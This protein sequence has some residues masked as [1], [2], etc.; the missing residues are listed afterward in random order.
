MDSVTKEK[1]SDL[2]IKRWKK[3]STII[4]PNL[5][6]DAKFETK[7]Q[8]VVLK[9]IKLQNKSLEEEVEKVLNIH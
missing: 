3:K 2:V 9:E 8:N 1:H 7:N 4:E 5:N 6:L